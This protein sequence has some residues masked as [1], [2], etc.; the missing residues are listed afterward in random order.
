M[1]FIIAAGANT[2]QN[3]ECSRVDVGGNPAN[4]W[5][6]KHMRKL[7]VSGWNVKSTEDL[8]ETISWLFNEGH[9]K[10]CMELVERYKENPE[11]L[12]NKK[13]FKTKQRNMNTIMDTIAK[14]IEKQGILAWDLCRVCNVAG[15]G[16]LA[17]YITYEEA[18]QIS[19]DACEILQASYTSWD[20]MME[21]YF[22][23]LWYWCEDYT[24]TQNRMG[25]Y[26]SS[27]KNS[28]SIYNIPWDTVLN[29]NDVISPRKK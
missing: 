3:A 9:N 8:R 10:E 4:S 14:K 13:L 27:K 1:R 20:D 2:Y 18:I 17:Q 22:L 6:K 26:E 21:S 23:G 12:E 25:W 29:P 16:F 11:F 5:A 7:L 15:W 28:E 19:V 24:T